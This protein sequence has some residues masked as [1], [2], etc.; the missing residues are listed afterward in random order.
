MSQPNDEFETSQ[1][2]LINSKNQVIPNYDLDNKVINISIN[3]S[4]A[5]KVC[6]IG[7]VDSNYSCWCSITNLE[8]IDK[9]EKIFNF[10][11]TNKFTI[12]SHEYL[13]LGYDQYEDITEWYR[14]NVTRSSLEG[15]AW[16]TPFGHYYGSL[17]QEDH[18]RFFARNLLRFY[19]ELREKCIYRID[20]GAYIN[21]LQNYLTILTKEVSYKKMEP[22]ISILACEAYLRLSSNETIREL[23]LQCIEKSNELY[24]RYMDEA[25]G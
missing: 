4:R 15:K 12:F 5:K 18:G 7:Q 24:N 14:C 19:E 8:D 3:I 9:N 22:L 11:A 20:D 23:Y 16:K 10:I 25:R 6:I 17:N 21:T 1:Y 2:N 13:A